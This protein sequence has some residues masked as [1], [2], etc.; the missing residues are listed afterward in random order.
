MTPFETAD[1]LRAHDNYLILTH[2]RPDGDTAGSAAG[3]CLALRQLG[4]TAH[5]LP[6]PE[7]TALFAPYLDGLLSPEGWEPDTVVAVDMAAR[8]MFPVNAQK[9]GLAAGSLQK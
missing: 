4:K 8:N 7:L 6:N 3:L 1:F 5:V 2:A 9:A